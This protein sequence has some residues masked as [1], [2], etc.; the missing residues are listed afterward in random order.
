M[1]YNSAKYTFSNRF[2]TKIGILLSYNTFK[3]WI[4]ITTTNWDNYSIIH[5]NNSKSENNYNLINSI[6][7]YALDWVNLNKLYNI[8]NQGKYI[9]LV[10]KINS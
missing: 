9:Y 5:N 7:N 1:R 2:Y 10:L 6:F 8:Y 3:N 4:N